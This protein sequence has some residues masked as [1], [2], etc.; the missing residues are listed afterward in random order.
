MGIDS[1]GRRATEIARATVMVGIVF[2]AA[3]AAAITALVV[4]TSIRNGRVA[5]PEAPLLLLVV[6]MLL[7][8]FWL[9]DFL[10]DVLRDKVFTVENSKRLYK[11]AWLMIGAAIV[12]SIAMAVA[13][14]GVAPLVFGFLQ[15]GVLSGLLILV[16]ASAWRYGSELQ[17]ERDLTV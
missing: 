5:M 3:G 12:K 2:V 16:L 1:A 15:P 7:G 9:R 13:A 4:M 14:R 11:I 6:P 17:N 10:N 8:L